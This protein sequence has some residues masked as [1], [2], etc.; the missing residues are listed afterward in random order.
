MPTIKS[1]TPDPKQPAASPQETISICSQVNKQKYE[2]LD[3]EHE[4]RD[5]QR[6]PRFI[7][8]QYPSPST[9]ASTQRLFADGISLFRHHAFYRF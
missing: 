8:I 3:R 4:A 9:D 6:F 5:D 1:A 7:I 2:A